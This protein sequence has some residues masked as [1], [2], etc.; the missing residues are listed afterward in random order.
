[1]YGDNNNFFYIEYVG[2]RYIVSI[3]VGFV[4]VEFIFLFEFLY[5]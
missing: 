4:V 5:L 1:M 3:V 2:S